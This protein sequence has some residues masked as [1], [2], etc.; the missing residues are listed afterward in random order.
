MVVIQILHTVVGGHPLGIQSDIF[1]DR[2]GKVIG[3][4]EGAVVGVPALE[5]VALPS[6]ICN[7]VGGIAEV[8]GLAGVGLAVVVHIGHG[9]LS[10]IAGIKGVQLVGDRTAFHAGRVAGNRDLRHRVDVL[11]AVVIQLGQLLPSIGPNR[12]RGI[13][14]R[15][16]I[17]ASI[18]EQI[19]QNRVGTGVVGVVRVLPYLV[20]REGGGVVIQRAVHHKHAVLS[21]GRHIEGVAGVTQSGIALVQV[22]RVFLSVHG[23]GNHMGLILPQQPGFRIVHRQVIPGGTPI[24]SLTDCCSDSGGD[25]FHRSAGILAGGVIQLHLHAVRPLAGG[26]VVI[27]PGIQEGDVPQLRVGVG[28]GGRTI[29]IIPVISDLEMTGY[30]HAAVHDLSFHRMIGNQLSAFI[31]GQIVPSQV[32]IS[33]RIEGDVLHLSAGHIDRALAVG[34]EADRSGANSKVSAAEVPCLGHVVARRLGRVGQGDGVSAVLERYAGG[35]T[36]GITRV[37]VR[38]G[39]HSDVRQVAISEFHALVKQRGHRIDPLG[40]AVA[41]G[42]QNAGGIR[43]VDIVIIILLEGKCD[44]VGTDAAAV[45]VVIP[46]H[47]DGNLLLLVVGRAVAVGVHGPDRVQGGVPA[48]SVGTALLIH[49]SRRILRIGDHAVNVLGPAQEGIAFVG[50]VALAKHGSLSVG[51]AVCCLVH[52][53]VDAAVG[54]VGQRPGIGR[55]GVLDGN[56]RGVAL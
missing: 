40:V 50:H 28:D 32:L 35:I 13:Q 33:V 7:A 12:K 55:V 16:G 20:H 30:V 42:D 27:V 29:L 38:L 49:P 47:I 2:S 25:R 8:H 53:G 41:G 48:Q 21:E 6:G 46:D 56:S 11:H 1:G 54:V 36:L 39:I 19:H 51:L 24:P 34:Q 45:S 14:S 18:L 10:G 43:Q 15:S 23:V 52:R 31:L 3:I 9:Q 26:V 44:A 37:G 4:C 5:G 17:D 22:D